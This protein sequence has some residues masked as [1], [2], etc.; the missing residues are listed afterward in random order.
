MPEPIDPAAP[1]APPTPAAPPAAPA[2]VAD[3]KEPS[4]LAERLER[5]RT[6]TTKKILDDIGAPDAKTAKDRL[7]AHKAL[8][9]SKKT[10]DQRLREAAARVD[11]LTQEN[12]RYVETIK[13]IAADQLG[14]LSAEHQATVKSLAGEDPSKQIETIR[15]LRAG[16]L[17]AKG[18][19][20]LAAPASTAAPK[21]APAAAPTSSTDHLR[22]YEQLQGQNPMRAAQ[23][24]Q[25]HG[26]EI[27]AQRAQQQQKT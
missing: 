5:E 18:A 16:G 25:K 11:P 26:Q 14:A 13:S 2:P 8:E 22:T 1:A 10:D 4:W 27:H 17:L 7:D 9:E 3:D 21:G 23:Y 15:T 12:T 24:M 20:P 6:K 19:A